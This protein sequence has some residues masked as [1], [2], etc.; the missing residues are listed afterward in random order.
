MNRKFSRIY[1]DTEFWVG[2]LRRPYLTCAN[3]DGGGDDDDYGDGD[4]DDFVNKDYN[5]TR[6]E[7][8]KNAFKILSDK[9]A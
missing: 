3:N 2:I 4:D 6:M 7:E 8:D 9:P 5:V 1:L